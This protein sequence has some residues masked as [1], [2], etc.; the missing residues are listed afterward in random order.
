VIPNDAIAELLVKPQQQAEPDDGRTLIDDLLADQRR[1]TA[2]E[3]FSQR[4]ERDELPPLERHYRD[5]IPLSAPTPGKQFAFE[6]DLD[7]CSGCK[8]CVTACHSLNGL[9]E[10]ESWRDVGALIS[11]DWRRPFQQTVTTACHHCVDPGCLN[12]CPVLAYE[13]DPVTGIV[14]HL[15]D[16]CIGC[17]YCILKCPYDVPKYS[18]E[19]GIVRKCD[20]CSQ[21]L[22]VGEAPAC[23]QA[24]PNEAIRIAIIDQQEVSI[25][26]RHRTNHANPFLPGAPEP[27]VTIPTTRYVSRE[28]LPSDL[29]PADA[30]ETRLQPAHWPLVWMLMLTQLSAGAFA[31]LP[32]VPSTAGS[33][34]VLVGFIAAVVGLAAS[35]LHLGKPMKAWRSF[36]GLRRS[37]L[38]REIV[39]FGLFSVL[40]FLTTTTHWV[41]SPSVPRTPSL[42]PAGGE[43]VQRPGEREA[44][45][46]TSGII[47]NLLSGTTAFMGL[48]GVFCSAMVYHDTRRVFWR[49]WRA[50]GKFFGT[51][52]VLGLA[53]AWFA[54]ELN[55]VPTW[56]LP[57]ALTLAA[58]LKLAGEHRL[59]RSAG[60]DIAEHTF[61]KYA[62]F[63]NWSLARSVLLMRD[64]FGLVTRARF[65]F[66]FTGGV[67]L[68]L[69]SYLPV[70]HPAFLAAGAL[71]VCTLTE[72]GERYLFFRAV[73]PPR[74]PGTV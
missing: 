61:P 44:R 52:A 22:A 13:K 42:S 46:R 32:L 4:Y 20:M 56:W 36:L 66:G 15:D 55:E 45:T 69:L 39:V 65:S 62:E 41:S 68:P 63:E 54:A 17:Q 48:L 25:E 33:I 16:Q 49:G 64:P 8:A 1:L 23:V 70:T 31:L 3:K 2:V 9:D 10:G 53:A 35:M 24:C 73:V 59:L 5:L 38:S 28:P 67:V 60:T 50:I 6:V 37:W 74:M 18:A 29:L 26:F 11:E 58:T 34:L 43:G 71:L 40:A 27:G 14:H 57:A 19:R 21:R 72:L 47:F 51:T 7:K 30:A 12:G